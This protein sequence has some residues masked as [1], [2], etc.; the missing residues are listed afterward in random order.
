MSRP[1]RKRQKRKERKR[2]GIWLKMWRRLEQQSKHVHVCVFFVSFWFNN[3]AINDINSRIRSANEK[4]KSMSSWPLVVH[5]FFDIQVTG[6]NHTCKLMK[7][8]SHDRSISPYIRGLL[9]SGMR[10]RRRWIPWPPILL[11][12]DPSSRMPWMGIW[13]TYI[14]AAGLGW[15]KSSKST[16]KYIFD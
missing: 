3:Q 1:Q 12:S 8:M 2:V 4:K 5:D 7:K 9:A 14:W 15:S 6:S 10:S 13:R 16:W 11:A